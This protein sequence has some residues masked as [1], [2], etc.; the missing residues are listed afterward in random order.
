MNLC[1]NNGAVF[2]IATT[3]LLFAGL[4]ASHG[5][6]YSPPQR[7][8][9]NGNRYIPIPTYHPEA[10]VD[11]G[12]HFPAG[13]KSTIPG[14]GLESQIESAGPLGWVPYEPEKSGFQFRAGVCGDLLSGGE[15][16]RGGRY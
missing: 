14:A 6:L 7:R 9:T 8:A 5:V 13:S 15:H 1:V 3:I 11:N 10:T 16:L 12:A 4:G 2:F